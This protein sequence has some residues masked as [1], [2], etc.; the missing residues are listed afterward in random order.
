MVGFCT[1]RTPAIVLRWTAW[2]A[3]MRK[4][5]EIGLHTCANRWL[6]LHECVY[7][8]IGLITWVN[9]K[10]G[11]HECVNRWLTDLFTCAQGQQGQQ[12]DYQTSQ[13]RSTTKRGMAPRPHNSVGGALKARSAL[14][15]DALA[16][17]QAKVCGREGVRFCG[18]TSMW[19]EC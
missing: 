5:V 4:H 16:L 19:G 18:L 17:A 13:T 14:V 3:C 1:S 12:S 15:E 9:E 7:R 11:V 2:L 8:Q 6:G 10:L